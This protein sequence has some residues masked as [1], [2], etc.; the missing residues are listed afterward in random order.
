VN[1]QVSTRRLRIVK[2][3]GSLHGTNE[4]PFLIG[5]DGI[6]V[7]PITSSRLEHGAST[8]RI[9]SGV[10]ELDQMLGGKG[11]YRGSSILLT[12]TA[13]TGK[14]SLAAAFVEAACRRGERCL[15]LAFEESRDQIIRNM[16]SIGIDLQPYLDRGLLRI[17]AARATLTGLE[18]HLLTIRDLMEEWKPKVMVVDPITDFGVVGSVLEVKAAVA[19]MID[20]MKSYGIT[21]LLISLVPE[22]TA[23]AESVVGISSVTDT[24]ISL[25]NLEKNGERHRGLYILK[26][27]GMAHSHQVRSFLLT[28]EGIRIGDLDQAGRRS[29]PSSM[30]G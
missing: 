29:G 15:Y 26:S 12:G 19:R 28:D 13:G 20:F 1:E 5:R 22:D 11:F 10:Q 21:A 27:R 14:S 18:M 4:Y 3:R 2:Y 24:W 9:S 25:R 6:S 23:V 16:R 8:E 30:S 7:M 17:H